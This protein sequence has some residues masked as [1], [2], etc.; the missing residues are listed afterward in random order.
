VV[1]EAANLLRRYRLLNAEY[2]PGGIFIYSTVRIGIAIDTGNGLRV[3]A[4]PSVTLTSIPAVERAIVSVAERSQAG[5]LTRD[6]MDG[7][8]F[9]ISDLSSERVTS[10]APVLNRH[11]SG[12]LGIGCQ[13]SEKEQVMSITFDHHV[14]EGR[15]AAGLVTELPDRLD[16]S[17]PLDM[18]NGNLA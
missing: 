15:Y 11:Q 1:L 6:D 5:Q 2:R 16:S 7:I 17:G 9:T 14:T 8:T 12:I 18:L 10:F 13:N 3:A 4:I